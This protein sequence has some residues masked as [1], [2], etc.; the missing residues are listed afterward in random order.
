MSS[1]RPPV[2]CSNSLLFVPIPIPGIGGEVAGDEG[3]SNAVT[4]TGGEVPIG[5][6]GE[7]PSIE[8]ALEFTR[9]RRSLSV[10]A[11]L[12]GLREMEEKA[13]L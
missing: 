12:L 10:S 6:K 4:G 1:T 7:K 2:A 8:T 13:G 3:D 9:A 5:G 11:P